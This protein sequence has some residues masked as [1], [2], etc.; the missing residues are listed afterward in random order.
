MARPAPSLLGSPGPSLTRLRLWLKPWRPQL[1]WGASGRA[2]RG[3]W[4]RSDGSCW[5]LQKMPGLSG[6]PVIHCVMES[7][8]HLLCSYRPGSVLGA[9]MQ[10]RNRA[11]FLSSKTYTLSLELGRFVSEATQPHWTP[12]Q[13]RKQWVIVQ[14]PTEVFHCGG[15][16]GAGARCSLKH[17]T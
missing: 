10:E 14:V 17:C 1:F 15:C 11:S 4:W 13:P 3:R 8:L 2:L 9:G 6:K 12:G 7:F 16:W 5:G